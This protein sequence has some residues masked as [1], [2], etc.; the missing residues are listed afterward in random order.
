[1]QKPALYTAAVIFAVISTVHWLR[2][3]LKTEIVVGGAPAPLWLSLAAGVIFALL[4]VWL[5]VAGRRS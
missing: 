4:A 2:L 5:A 1:M 3:F